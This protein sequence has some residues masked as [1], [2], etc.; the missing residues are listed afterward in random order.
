MNTLEVLNVAMEKQEHGKTVPIQLS[1]I[2]NGKTH[3][4]HVDRED[5]NVQKLVRSLVIMMLRNEVD[6]TVNDDWKKSLSDYT[7]RVRIGSARNLWNEI[8][9]STHSPLDARVM[10]FILVSNPGKCHPTELVQLAKANTE[11]V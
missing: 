8:T 4:V 7:V 1:I 5:K 2:L 10:A 9:V 3:L 6:K 11:I